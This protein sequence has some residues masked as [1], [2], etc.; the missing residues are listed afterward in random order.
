MTHPESALRAPRADEAPDYYSIPC[1]CC[2]NITFME[3]CETVQ[4]CAV[5]GWCDE[6]WIDGIALGAAKAC[7]RELGA[8]APKYVDQCRPPRSYER[9]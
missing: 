7:F 6:P 8:I 5:C 1:D 2:M 3:D 9:P 4:V